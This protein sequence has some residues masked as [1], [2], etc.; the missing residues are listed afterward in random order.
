MNIAAV[1]IA[2]GRSRRFGATDKRLALIDGEALLCRV[3]R[4]VA[5]SA[6]SFIGVVTA[7]APDESADVLQILADL[8]VTQISNSQYAEGMGTSISAGIAALETSIDAALIVPADMPE[9]SPELINLLIKAF[10]DRGGESVFVP[11]DA[12]GRQRNPVLWPRKLFRELEGLDGA[13]GAKPLIKAHKDVV[14]T[15]TWPDSAAFGDI[16]TREE[17]QAY[18]TSRPDSKS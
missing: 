11:V 9:I 15:L 18:V 4:R 16:D 8:P 13:S 10:E 14:E 1:I 7:P 12:G 2:A 6:V 17:L 3:I 5:T